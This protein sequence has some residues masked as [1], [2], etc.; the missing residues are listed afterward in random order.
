MKEAQMKRCEQTKKIGYS[1]ELNVS[2]VALDKAP[3]MSD[4]GTKND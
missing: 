2:G 3:N 4:T 1:T